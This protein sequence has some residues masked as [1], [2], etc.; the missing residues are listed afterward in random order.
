MKTNQISPLMAAFVALFFTTIGCN[1]PKSDTANKAVETT[2][3]ATAEKPDMGAIKVEIQAIENTWATAAN[4]KDAATIVNFYADDA[5]SFINNKPMLTGKTAIKK[6]IDEQLANHKDTRIVTY[7]T[8]DVYGDDNVVTEMG[9]T[10]AKDTKGTVT[11]AGKYMAI[12]EKRNDKWLVVR[13]M[14]NDD[15][16][17]K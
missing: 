10:T 16:K 9:K 14:Y 2:Q 1:T 11:Y 13:D 17:E 4:G 12:W 7:E 6:E 8:L 5:V 3:Q 15:A